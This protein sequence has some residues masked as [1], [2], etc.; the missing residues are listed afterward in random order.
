MISPDE[1]RA[2]MELAD[3]LLHP[4]GLLEY[5]F[6]Q[7]DEIL[8]KHPEEVAYFVD[9]FENE[10]HAEDRDVLAVIIIEH[11]A[12]AGTIRFLRRENGWTDDDF[13]GTAAEGYK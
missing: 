8:Q 1:K 7:I 5:T 10:E 3:E 9:M 13:K 11:L 4:T 12:H 6:M 2:L